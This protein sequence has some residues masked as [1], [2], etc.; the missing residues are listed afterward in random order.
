[1]YAHSDSTLY[2]VDLTNKALVVI[3]PFNASAGSGS[4]TG[5]VVMTDLAVAPDGTIYV[6]SEQALYTA[7]ATNGQATM[8]GS[9]TSCGTEMVALT[10]TADGRLFVGDFHG[11][12]CEID[13]TTN[14]PTVK[15]PMT[16]S[17]GMALTGD[18][19]G[20]GNGTIYGTAYNTADHSGSGTQASN[21]LVT[22][23]L[24]NGNTTV[25]GPTGYPDLFGVAAANNEIFGF[26]HDGTGHVITIDPMT[27]AGAPFGT[28]TDPNSGQGIAFAGAGVNSMVAVTIQ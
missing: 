28:F 8:V 2:S 17:N 18:F 24:T 14:P 11:S 22:V 10:N 7:S 3:G 13:I 20:V 9:L 1:M 19:V 27:G 23:D 12:L 16:M 25:I 4:A 26:T 5:N 15:P 6:I 21:D